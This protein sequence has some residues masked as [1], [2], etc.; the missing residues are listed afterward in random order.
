MYRRCQRLPFI[1]SHLLALCWDALTKTYLCDPGQC[2]AEFRQRRVKDRPYIF[3]ENRLY[4]SLG[5]IVHQSREFD[6][7]HFIAIYYTIS[8]CCL[9]VQD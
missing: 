6:E 1:Y 8:A 4:S 9:K 2:C 3:V 7:L 5:E